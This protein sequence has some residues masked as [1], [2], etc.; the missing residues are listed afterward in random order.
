MK[1]HCI[2]LHDWT[3]LYSEK[4][5]RRETTTNASADI[6]RYYLI[7]SYGFLKDRLCAVCVIMEVL[8]IFNKEFKF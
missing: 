8:Q 1:F 6:P 4:S 7:S 2:L 5:T 3:A